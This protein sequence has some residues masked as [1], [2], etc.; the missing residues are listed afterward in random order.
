MTIPELYKSLVVTYGRQ[1]Q[2]DQARAFVRALQSFTSEEV[3]A[4]IAAWQS[5]TAADWDGRPLGAKMPTP[6]DLRSLCQRSEERATAK[7]R[8]Q[9]SPCG[10]CQEGW[11]TAEDPARG[12]VVR[13]CQCWGDW[14]A[15]LP[16]KQR[17]NPTHNR[18]AKRN[19]EFQTVDFTQSTF[20]Q[21]ESR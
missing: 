7:A 8:G 21:M 10:K 16:S 18:K 17:Q 9:F 15:M 4:A 2:E 13:R 5:N 20:S 6:A 19:S 12:T 1:F 3:D 14:R 11:V